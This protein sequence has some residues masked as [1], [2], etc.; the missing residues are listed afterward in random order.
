M[1][2]RSRSPKRNIRSCRYCHYVG[3]RISQHLH[4]CKKARDSGLT[5][6]QLVDQARLDATKLLKNFTIKSSELIRIV[7]MLKLRDR[8]GELQAKLTSCGHFITMDH[9]E[10]DLDSPEEGEP[11]RKKCKVELS[12]SDDDVELNRELRRLL[13]DAKPPFIYDP[14]ET[15]SFRPDSTDAKMQERGLHK[16][17]NVDSTFFIR[18]GYYLEKTSSNKVAQQYLQIVA[19]LL[20]YIFTKKAKADLETLNSDIMVAEKIVVKWVRRFFEKYEDCGA[21]PNTMNTLVK[22]TRGLVSFLQSECNITVENRQNLDITSRWLTSRDKAIRR[23][24][25]AHRR[26]KRIDRKTG[27]SFGEIRS[28]FSL[29]KTMEKYKAAKVTLKKNYEEDQ[30]PDEEAFKF[31]AQYCMA[32][33][34]LYYGNRPE[35]AQNFTIREWKEKEIFEHNSVEVAVFQVFEHKTRQARDAQK[36]ILDKSQRRSFK[37]YFKYGRTRL[38]MPAN[39]EEPFFIGY[40]SKKCM[41]NIPTALKKFQRS[42]GILEK[43]LVT[44]TDV[45]HAI[46]TT[47]SGHLRSNHEKRA[48]HELQGHTEVMARKHYTDPSSARILPAMA[49]LNYL[50]KV[51][52]SQPRKKTQRAANILT[53]P[54]FATSMDVAGPSDADIKVYLACTYPMDADSELIPESQLVNDEYLNCKSSPLKAKKWYDYIKWLRSQAR[55]RVIA[56]DI[57]HQFAELEIDDG[58]IRELALEN[59]KS[60]NWL[61][62]RVDSVVSVVKKALLKKSQA[63]DGGKEMVQRQHQEP[64]VG[65][66]AKSSTKKVSKDYT[67]EELYEM[68]ED[69]R[70]WIGLEV[71][72]NLGMRGRGVFAMVNF[73]SGQIICNYHGKKVTQEQYNETIE[74]LTSSDPATLEKLSNYALSMRAED[75]FNKGK[76]FVILA[77]EEDGSYGRLLNHSA[78]H[79][80]CYSRFKVMTKPS[81]EQETLAFIKANRNI[82]K[83]EELLWNY[84]D[85]FKKVEWYHNCPCKKCVRL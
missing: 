62:V 39:D 67:D 44:V 4:H 20:A 9:E 48:I 38:A 63:G 71:R 54:D 53:P 1:A 81:G 27:K 35:V 55:I 58:M 83:G 25:K 32:S 65:H 22:A 10:K 57:I 79:P 47:A 17:F 56:S 21:V 28:I 61:G 80:N 37:F 5:H 69:Q 76:Y 26:K 12:G 52:E 36:F 45:R 33:I 42:I 29:P 16:R 30:P 8:F 11:A 19:R 66:S 46:E 41:R 40:R 7:K 2:S 85:E 78:K 13:V 49:A 60:Q 24:I 59:L 51:L 64:A 84:G 3:E 18:L 77:H 23:G 68:I 43:D 70:K 31:M 15:T 82:H 50:E 14:Q 74:E 75:P 34:S 6:K 72:E 73:A